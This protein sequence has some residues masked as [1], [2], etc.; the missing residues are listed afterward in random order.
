MAHSKQSWWFL[1]LLLIL[2]LDFGFPAKAAQNKARKHWAFQK[3]TRPTLPALKRGGRPR[4]PV[5]AFILAG[6]RA[7]ELDFSPD[8]SR[9]TLVRRIYL[10]LIGLPPGPKEVLAFVQ[11]NRADALEQLLDQL[12]ASPHFGE[13]WGRHWLD[14]AGYSDVTGTDNDAGIIRQSENKWRYRDYVIH[15]F[16]QDKPFDRFL[17]EQIAGDEL[18]DW[19]AAKNFT[20]EIRQL[21]IATGFLRM[22]ADDTGEMS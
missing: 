12:L 5:D 9:E 22:A 2:P 14:S 10:D 4:T 19:R 11:D 17:L 3:L 8:A 13:R 18:V 1:L 20:A 21:L 6:L 16:N 15:S 7:K